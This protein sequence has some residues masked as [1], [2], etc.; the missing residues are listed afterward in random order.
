MWQHS[1]GAVLLLRL[2]TLL[3][4]P[5]VGSHS[6]ADNPGIATALPDWGVFDQES[7]QVVGR[8]VHEEGLGAEE[9]TSAAAHTRAGSMNPPSQSAATSPAAA[10]A[11]TLRGGGLS[12]R[13]RGE[14]SMR[15]INHTLQLQQRDKRG[16]RRSLARD[17]CGWER[18]SGYFMSDFAKHPGQI[19]HAVFDS[20]TEAQAD[21][22]EIG[23]GCRGV[24]CTASGEECTVRNHKHLR[25]SSDKEDTLVKTGCPGGFVPGSLGEDGSGGQMWTEGLGD[26]PAPPPTADTEV[27]RNGGDGPKTTDD[28]SEN[29][30]SGPGSTGAADKLSTAEPTVDEGLKPAETARDA[31]GSSVGHGAHGVLP[32]ARPGKVW[33]DRQAP[34]L[35]NTH[36]E[37]LR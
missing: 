7:Q 32:Q 28:F 11:F 1:V 13:T 35:I 30:S 18:H 26:A 12:G 8:R 14:L 34:R 36:R 24:T 27:S 20:L 9:M 33:Y 2:P 17:E 5:A 3:L 21:C 22:I 31:V 37:I 29:G 15:R 25:V 4:V 10:S 23:E 6:A 19:H 16:G